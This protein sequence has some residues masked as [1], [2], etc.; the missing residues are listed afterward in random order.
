MIVRR[1]I[2]AAFATMLAGSVWAANLGAPTGRVLLT[3]SGAIET[4]NQG[5]TA[6]FD[7]ALL[8]ELDWQEITTFTHY[9]EG[10]QT[11]SGPT[12]ASLLEALGV[13][14][15]TLRAVALDDYAIEI[16]V[17][18]LAKH[19]VL[20]AMEHNGER[21]RVRNRGPIWVIYPATSPDDIVQEHI[22]HS[23]WQL[24]SIEVMR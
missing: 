1:A 16:P 7:L 11:F 13:R 10:L 15:G 21:M 12:L 24:T 2:L 22:S 17:A 8:E 9:T 20:L 14:D 5:D 3:V 18:D 4:V 6:A 23:I 19:E